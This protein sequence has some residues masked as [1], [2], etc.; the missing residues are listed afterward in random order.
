MINQ[1]DKR[2]KRL[3]KLLCD[4]CGWVRWI[5]PQA[6]SKFAECPMCQKEPMPHEETTIVVEEVVF[7]ERQIETQNIIKKKKSKR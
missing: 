7:E 3:I 5:P 6:I 4:E 1:V 2:G